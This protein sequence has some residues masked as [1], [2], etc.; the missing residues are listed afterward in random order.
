MPV[1][2]SFFFFL[3][4]YIN[5]AEK[6]HLWQKQEWNQPTCSI[7]LFIIIAGFIFPQ[8][9]FTALLQLLPVLMLILISVFTQMMATNPPYS[10][11]YKPWAETV[12]FCP[13][14]IS[15]NSQV[16]P[17]F[18]VWVFRWQV[19]GAGGVQRNAAYGRAILRG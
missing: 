3:P 2:F 16:S 11:F 12:F 14:T 8:N 4:L 6:F 19:H 1:F 9:T 18:D 10:L 15:V 13:Q 5:G 7:R 17:W